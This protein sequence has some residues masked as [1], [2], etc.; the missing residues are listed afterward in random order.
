MANQHRY[1]LRGIRNVDDQ[2]WEDFAAAT[3][4]QGVDR[5]AETR[6]FWEWYVRRPGAALPERPEPGAIQKPP[7][8]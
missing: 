2:L 7:S 5:S 8:D 4:A 3:A 6:K 1:K